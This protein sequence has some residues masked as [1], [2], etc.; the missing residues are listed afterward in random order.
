MDQPPPYNNENENPA[1]YPPQ[2][3]APQGYQPQHHQPQGYPPQGHPPQGYPTQGYPPQGYPPQ[4]YSYQG[5]QPQGY[6]PPPPT[7]M[8]QQQQSNNT[9]VV[10]ANQPQPAAV[11]TMIPVVNDHMIL[12]IL[13]CV[14]CCWPIGLCA[15]IKSSEAR[16]LYI[17]GD[18][19][20]AMVSA[21][22]ARN[23]ALIALV[24][25]ICIYP[26]IIILRLVVFAPTY[27]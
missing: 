9:T 21:R 12:S 4:G 13:A 14:F 22:T 6:Q 17:A 1:P 15:I 19:A 10:V 18:Y 26:L 11:T 27:N 2:Q 16:N 3:Q 24:C 5:Y 20:N 23:L 7:G 25:G 8:M